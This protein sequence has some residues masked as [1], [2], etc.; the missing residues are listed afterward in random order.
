MPGSSEDRAIGRLRH[1]PDDGLI[2]GKYRVDLGREGETAV[3]AERDALEPA[4][5]EILI[6]ADF[7]R[8]R[9]RS[10]RGCGQRKDREI[11]QEFHSLTSTCTV[12]EPLMTMCPR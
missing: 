1:A 8:R 12:F 11:S 2:G 10:V 4:A 6:R 7:P 9:A 5:N 3:A